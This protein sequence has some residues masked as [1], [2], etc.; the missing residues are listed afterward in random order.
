[1]EGGFLR[2]RVEKLM[3]GGCDK[4]KLVDGVLWQVECVR[5]EVPDVSVQ[6]ILCFVDSEWPLFAS[7]FR[8]SG[9]EVLWPKKLVAWLRDAAIG[10]VD[11]AAVTELLAVRFRAA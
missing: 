1:M 11:I 9:V 8:V 6:G 10:Q 5:K 3:V 7:P 4:S 2:P